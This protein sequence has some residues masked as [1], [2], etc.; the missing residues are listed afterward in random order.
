MTEAIPYLY[1]LNTSLYIDNHAHTF[2]QPIRI[3]HGPSRQH[4]SSR[5]PIRIEHDTSRQTI[6]DEPK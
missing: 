2:D 1:T 5:Q 6:R 4:D 3:E